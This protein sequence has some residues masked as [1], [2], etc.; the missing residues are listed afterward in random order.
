MTTETEPSCTLLFLYPTRLTNYSFMMKKGILE[1]LLPNMNYP[2]YTSPLYSGK[3]SGKQALR[4]IV[5]SLEFVGLW[6]LKFPLKKT[7]CC[8]PFSYYFSSADNS[9]SSSVESTC[10]SHRP[11]LRLKPTKNRNPFRNPGEEGDTVTACARA[12]VNPT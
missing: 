2:Y 8:P 5:P 9:S 12:A 3:G 4:T 11:V 6:V 1:D 7:V 10:A